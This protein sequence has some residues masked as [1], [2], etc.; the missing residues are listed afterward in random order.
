[1]PVLAIG[2]DAPCHEG[3]AGNDGAH[4]GGVG[5]PVGGLRVP[6]AGRGPDVLGVA[7]R[8]VSECE[9]SAHWYGIH[10]VLW[11]RRFFEFVRVSWLRCVCS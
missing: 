2:A 7:G 5:F 9:R 10:T 1:M 3:N 6:A 4:D 11:R 8:D